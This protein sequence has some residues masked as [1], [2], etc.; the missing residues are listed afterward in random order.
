VNKTIRDSFS[1]SSNR[2]MSDD[3]HDAKIKRM[4]GDSERAA[5]RE[6]H[7][8]HVTHPVVTGKESRDLLDKKG[9]VS[10][11]ARALGTGKRLT[12]GP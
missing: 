9:A 6:E 12:K 7:S 8:G 1:R 3:F 5:Q 4:L 11:E 10:D 2:K